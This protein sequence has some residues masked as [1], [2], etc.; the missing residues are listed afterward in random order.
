MIV[1]LW[2]FKSSRNK[3]G[4]NPKPKMVI[5]RA[6]TVEKD[7]FAPERDEPGGARMFIAGT[8]SSIAI[9]CRAWG[10]AD[11]NRFSLRSDR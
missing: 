2:T 4:H 1:P 5:L 11:L 3:L 9:T 7:R 10:V 8:S 6:A